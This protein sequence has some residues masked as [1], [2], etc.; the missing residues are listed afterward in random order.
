M[1]YSRSLGIRFPLEA[2]REASK[3]ITIGVFPASEPLM[4]RADASQIVEFGNSEISRL[5][6]HLLKVPGDIYRITPEQFEDLVLDRIP[7]YG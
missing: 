5:I 7:G 2:N 4:H 1:V 3:N 6:A